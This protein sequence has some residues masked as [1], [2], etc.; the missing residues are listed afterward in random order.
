MEYEVRLRNFL[1][2]DMRLLRSW[3]TLP[4]VI[5]WYHNPKLWIEELRGRFDKF[6]YITHLMVIVD[7]KPIGFCQYYQ[8][9]VAGEDW[10]GTIRREDTYSMDYL[11]GD[12]NYLSKG[13]APKIIDLL[14]KKI[15]METNAKQII[16]QP[17]EENLKSRRALARAGYDFDFDNKLFIKI[18]QD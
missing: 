4:H 16:V 17:E 2:T 9:E 18:K 1:D 5:K 3:L 8:I 10:Y 14:T 15:F 12:T 7:D 13:L 6:S 11:I